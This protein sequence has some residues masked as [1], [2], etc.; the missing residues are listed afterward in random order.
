MT[1]RKKAKNKKSDPSYSGA[2]DGNQETLWF[3]SRLTILAALAAIV[4]LGWYIRLEDYGEW[5][6]RPDI[7]FNDEQPLLTN[8]DGYFYLRLARDLSTGNYGPVDLLRTWPDHPVKPSPPPLLSVLAD[9]IHRIAPIS[10]AWIGVILP[11]FLGPLLVIPLFLYVRKA[12]GSVSMGLTAALMAVLSVQYATRT[13][14]G[15][16]DTD[17]MIVTFTMAAAYFSMRFAFEKSKLRYVWFVVGLAVYGF[18]LWWWH[19]APQV[20]TLICL[21][22]LG[23]ALVFFYRPPKR[24]ALLFT[25]C[26]AALCL[27]LLAILGLDFPL[28]FVKGFFALLGFV[29][30]EK[31][32][33]FPNSAGDISELQVPALGD[34]VRFTTAN[35]LVFTLS[36]AGFAWFVFQKR[37]ESLFM[38]APLMLSIFS[39]FFGNR[40]LIFFAP[41]TAL[42]LGYLVFRGW[43][44]RRYL[45]PYPSAVLLG[46][47]LF[48][49]WPAFRLNTQPLTG[50]IIVNTVPGINQAARTT[51]EDAL[52]WTSWNLGYPLMY[53]GSRKVVADGQ[54]LEGERL[55]Y[56]YF[57][58][59]TDNQRLAANFIHFFVKNGMTGMARIYAAAES[60]AQGFLFLKKVL[61]AG[62]E[63]ARSLI[64]SAQDSGELNTMGW[65]SLEQLVSYLFPTGNP[66]I[67]VLLHKEMTASSRW[68][69]YGLWDPVRREGPHA[70]Y[71][72]FFSL[73]EKN[74]RIVDA[75]GFG[76]ERGK[77]GR[78]NVD[79]DGRSAV[80]RLTHLFEHNGGKVVTLDYHVSEGGLRFEW[81]KTQHYG[82]LLSQDMAN[83][84]F[85]RLFIRH[86]ASPTY[87]RHHKLSTPSYQLWEVL[88]DKP[89]SDY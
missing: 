56:I 49:A 63:N 68:F 85:N 88:G 43:Q 54:S 53:Y 17:C 79:V 77:G 50:P 64:V 76:F 34:I 65:E 61:A 4:I 58:L 32:G 9:L 44:Y 71:K 67:F 80:Y 31:L 27:V 19:M 47:V 69:W 55:V 24:E 28:R 57:P 33:A 46:L 48:C 62:P 89:K 59:A 23:L 21:L 22:P 73:A 7:F 5:K 6:N 18:F 72:P 87:F 20:V 8:A 75:T 83:S 15:F 45:G 25:G 26:L 38:A 81:V 40:F 74:G 29:A 82:A 70:V 13:K 12:L 78:F 14:L 1:R 42:G 36:V 16:F 52:V 2:A 66:P 41:I 3:H 10:L 37:K 51:P 11:A 60:K 86:T 35:A 30:R 84:V 39:L